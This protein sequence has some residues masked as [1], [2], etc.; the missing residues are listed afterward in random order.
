MKRRYQIQ[1]LIIQQKK[2][3]W[4]YGLAFVIMI[5]VSYGLGN[6]YANYK[7]NNWGEEKEKLTKHL[8]KLNEQVEIT[9]QQVNEFEKANEIS[10][11]SIELLKA[12]NQNLQNNIN[13][14]QT[15]LSFYRRILGPT[16]VGTALVSVAELKWGAK[17]EKAH[18]R[19][20]MVLIQSGTNHE[21]QEGSIQLAV[22]G[23]QDNKVAKFF[24]KNASSTRNGGTLEYR[25]RY[26][27]N[28]EGDVVLPEAFIPEHVEVT[29]LPSKE[30][31]A[32]IKENFAWKLEGSDYVENKGKEAT[33]KP[34]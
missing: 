23:L 17:Q 2:S 30:G 12:T 25:F 7:H 5:F 21:W 29:L 16:E 26:F 10:K 32:E 18:Y 9:A 13:V 4:H 1:E 8:E 27:Q 31:V 28:L 3:F 22:V 14:L 33:R 34:V 6:W 15:D 24:V 11:Q 19:Y 20:R